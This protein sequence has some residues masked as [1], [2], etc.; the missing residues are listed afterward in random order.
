MPEETR[1][2]QTV[3]WTTAQIERAQE[4]LHV[5]RGLINE[6]S[7]DT[8]QAKSANS[9]TLALF[10]VALWQVVQAERELGRAWHRSFGTNTAPVCKDVTETVRRFRRLGLVRLKGLLAWQQT[11]RMV[12]QAG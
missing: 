1:T 12:K 8:D 10:D 6:A 4:L 2:H 5:V 7:R 11:T 3:C 9:F